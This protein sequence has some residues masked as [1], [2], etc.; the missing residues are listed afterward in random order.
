MGLNGA[1]EAAYH[2]VPIVTAPFNGERIQ[3]ALVFMKKVKMARFIDIL[4]TDAETWQHTIEEVIYNS[5]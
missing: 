1:A 4:N 2:G 3:N 5:R